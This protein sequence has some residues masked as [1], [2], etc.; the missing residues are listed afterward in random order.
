M[1]AIDGTSRDQV[2][3]QTV[4]WTDVHA[5]GIHRDPGPWIKYVVLGLVQLSIWLS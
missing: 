3:R 1:C 4:W 2:C 5:S